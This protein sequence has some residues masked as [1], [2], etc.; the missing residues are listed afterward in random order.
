MGDIRIE[1]L[2]IKLRTWC[3]GVIVRCRGYDVPLPAGGSAGRLNAIRL[4]LCETAHISAAG[5]TPR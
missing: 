5:I 1:P 3:H 2:A 4:R